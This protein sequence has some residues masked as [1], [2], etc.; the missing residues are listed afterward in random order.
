MLYLACDTL[1]AK[2]FDVCLIL[3]AVNKLREVGYQSFASVY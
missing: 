3:N 2:C 1:A